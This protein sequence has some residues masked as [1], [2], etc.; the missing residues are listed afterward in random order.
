MIHALNRDYRHKDRPT[1]VLSFAQAEG[2]PEEAPPSGGPLL[3][4]DIILSTDA[5]LRQARAGR[6]TLAAEVEWLLVHGM[7]HLLGYE[8]ETEAGAVCMEARGRAVMEKYASE[9]P[10]R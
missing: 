7:L 9:A 8:D 1:D 4:G 2:A 5:A 6:R 3:L 10:H